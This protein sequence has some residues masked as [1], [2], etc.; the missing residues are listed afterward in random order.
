MCAR[1]T[2]MKGDIDDLQ[3]FFDRFYKITNAFEIVKD[4][5][6]YAPCDLMTLIAL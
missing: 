6:N 3:P 1:G 2:A 5:L 4:R